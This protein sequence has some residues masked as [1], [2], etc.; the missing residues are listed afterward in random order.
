MSLKRKNCDEVWTSI[1]ETHKVIL[2]VTAKKSKIDWLPTQDI[3]SWDWQL[4]VIHWDREQRLLYIHGSENEGHYKGLA[5]AVGGP[6]VDLI[7][8]MDVFRALGGIK[9][10]QRLQNVGLI[11]Q[12]GGFVR[13]IMSAGPD[14]EPG[15]TG[16]ARQRGI[17]ANIFGIGYEN[18]GRTSIGCSYKGRLWSRKVETSM[19]SSNEFQ[20]VGRKVLDAS[21]D[22]DEVVR[23]T[24][25]PRDGRTASC[26]DAHWSGMARLLF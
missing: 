4:N 15:V 3:H 25:I 23:G 8:G 1:N 9:R 12:L 24:V 13:Y 14:V 20:M 26:T 16:Q 17:K 18:G 5:Q 21:I 22:P 7:C 2:V 11:Q 10:L 19:N 6:E